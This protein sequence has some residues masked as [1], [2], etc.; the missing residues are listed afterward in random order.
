M[1]K[2]SRVEANVD[3]GGR[4]QSDQVRSLLFAFFWDLLSWMANADG[5][6]P[7]KVK[8]YRLGEL[9]EEPSPESR[10]RHYVW[11]DIV[12]S[13]KEQLEPFLEQGYYLKPEV[14]DIIHS[15]V[16]SVGGREPVK[17]TIRFRNKSAVIDPAGVRYNFPE[18][19][20]LLHLRVRHDLELIEYATMRHAN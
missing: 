10:L 15:D 8:E 5:P 12:D 7:D 16:D 2:S 19:H 9:R 14:G 1:A 4:R 17:I 18:Q 13:W 11:G 20:W 3:E 6:V